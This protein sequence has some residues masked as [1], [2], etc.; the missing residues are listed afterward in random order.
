MDLCAL[1]IYYEN[2]PSTLGIGEGSL[3]RASPNLRVVAFKAIN[4]RAERP[5]N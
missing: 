5:E 4:L 2:S 1:K 3:P